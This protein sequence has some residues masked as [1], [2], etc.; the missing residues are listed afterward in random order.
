MDGWLK[1]KRK[2]LA[3]PTSVKAVRK[4]AN[5]PVGFC[6]QRSATT[7]PEETTTP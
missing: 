6:S 4:P 2:Q 3:K 1:R 5:F 7:N